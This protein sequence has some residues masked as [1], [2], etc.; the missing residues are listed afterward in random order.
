MISPTAPAAAK[1]ALASRPGFNN[2]G[3]RL[4][5]LEA[6]PYTDGGGIKGMNRSFSCQF[7]PGNRRGIGTAQVSGDMQR[8]HF[9]PC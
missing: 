1:A 9:L 2:P 6:G 5:G 4:Q 3:C 8:K 7:S